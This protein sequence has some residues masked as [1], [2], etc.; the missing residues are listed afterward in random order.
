V[1]RYG[2]F[3]FLKNGPLIGPNEREIKV[4]F[5]RVCKIPMTQAIVAFQ[6]ELDHGVPKGELEKWNESGF[7][8]FECW[9]KGLSMKLPEKSLRSK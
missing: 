2:Y 4:W 9:G 8:M 6:H 5:C 1:S 7:N 3:G